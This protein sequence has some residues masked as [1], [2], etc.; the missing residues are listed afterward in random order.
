MWYLF[1][2]IWLWLLAAFVLGWLSHWFFCCRN[3]PQGKTLTVTDTI[4]TP[5]VVATAAAIEAGETSPVIEPDMLTEDAGKPQGFITR[6]DQADDLKRIKGVGAVLE[7]TLNELGVYQFAQIAGWN[8]ENVAWVDD[9]LSF[10][11]RIERDDWIAQARTLATGGN[12]DFSSRVD[13]GDVDY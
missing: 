10:A 9:F 7:N 13:K 3:N 6:P 4:E 12:T 11:G 1:F 8:T 2:Q 5:P